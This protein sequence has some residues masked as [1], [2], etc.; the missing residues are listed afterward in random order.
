MTATVKER[1]EALAKLKIL[2]SKLEDA[3][4]EKGHLSFHTN[5]YDFTQTFPSFLSRSHLPTV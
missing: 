4:I 2:E 5:S 1:D 3:N